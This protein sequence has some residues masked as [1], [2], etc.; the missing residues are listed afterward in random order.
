M[1]VIFN[2]LFSLKF[3]KKNIGFYGY[4]GIW[5]DGWIEKYLMK[6]Y[7]R[8]LLMCSGVCLEYRFI[9]VCL[10][11]CLISVDFLCEGRCIS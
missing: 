4:L 10:F 11:V 3:D 2:S 9:F 1:I 8:V 7:F 5:D 6:G